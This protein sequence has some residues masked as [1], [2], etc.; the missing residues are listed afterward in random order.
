MNPVPPT[1][2]EVRA[3]KSPKILEEPNK[4]TQA[5]EV[6]EVIRGYADEGITDRMIGLNLDIGLNS[7][8]P[9]RKELEDRK[10]IYAK[11]SRLVDGKGARHNLWVAK[12]PEQIK[13]E[14]TA[15]KTRGA[16]PVDKEVIMSNTKEE[17]TEVLLKMDHCG[18]IMLTKDHVDGWFHAIPMGLWE[19]IIGFHKTVSE[20]MKSESVSYH[21]WNDKTQRYDTIIPYQ[22]TD[23]LAVHTDWG[24]P[25]NIALLDRYA[26]T[27]GVAF[28]P[29]CTIHTH[30]DI[31]AF[32]SGTD[33]ADE[34]D[35]PGWH[36]TIGHLLTHATYDLAARFRL[37]RV[38]KVRALADTDIG[39]DM[40][41]KHL[42]ERS[43][44]MAEITTTP[45]VNTHWHRYLDRV[46]RAPRIMVSAATASPDQSD[47][48]YLQHPGRGYQPNWKKH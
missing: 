7:I 9:R 18:E 12:P 28:F 29:A 6:L 43:V 40:D 11:Q 5:A 45:N 47:Y 10:L 24:L 33:A 16:S 32:E 20:T 13:R 19:M 27:W 37:P 38:P 25:K 36:L 35:L 41:E 1:L 14:R 4:G 23:G 31:P 48:E 15:L 3:A 39:H 8:S 44:T 46:K 30:V 21:R 2:Q 17:G 22:E 26:M 42:F 34:E